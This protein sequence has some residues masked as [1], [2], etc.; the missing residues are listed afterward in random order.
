MKNGGNGLNVTWQDNP[1]P[2]SPEPHP[3]RQSDRIRSGCFELNA[4]SVRGR[5]HKHDGS[6]RD[7]WYAFSVGERFAAICV[8]DGAGSKQ[9][10]RIG[11]KTAAE[12]AVKAFT[13]SII[14][15]DITKKLTAESESE[16]FTEAVGVI[17]AKLREAALSAA[18]AVENT[19]EEHFSADPESFSEDVSDY[20]STFLL[21]LIIPLHDDVIFTACLSVGDGNIAAFTAD[22]GIR[23]LGVEAHGDYS[24][25][26]E[27]LQSEGVLSENS[28]K[29][30]TRMI[31]EPIRRVVLATD[32]VADD[33]F[34]NETAFSK[35]DSDINEHFETLTDWLDE[36]YIRGSFDDRTLAVLDI[37][38]GAKT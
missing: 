9:F 14:D 26:T 31:R 23:I 18:Q 13:D 32:G 16:T 12:T 2:P 37:K 8:C 20:S 24:G 35:L 7:D 5:K 33:Y 11:A 3:E 25:E 6:N 28:L 15:D 29:A 27:F 10:S 19:A 1:V 30:R 21:A 34:P 36:Y 22:G 17:A 38:N 4:G